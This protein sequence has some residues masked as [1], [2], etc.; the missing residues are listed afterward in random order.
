MQITKLSSPLAWRA[1]WWAGVFPCRLT[2]SIWCCLKCC[3]LFWIP[4]MIFSI[5]M[6]TFDVSER[7]PI[8]TELSDSKV[9]SCKPMSFVKEMAT[10]IALASAS[11]G[12]SGSRSCMPKAACTSPTWSRTM[13]PIPTDL[14]LLK[15]AAS[16]LTF[17]FS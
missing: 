2:C 16:M 10:S 5:L 9:T 3:C 6:G 14:V 1:K 8:R 4:V 15:T 13:T 11:I 17:S 12:P 7:A